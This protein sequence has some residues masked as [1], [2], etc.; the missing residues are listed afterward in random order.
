MRLSQCCAYSP[1]PT[2]KINNST[3]LIWIFLGI[4]RSFQFIL[5]LHLCMHMNACR[6]GYTCTHECVHGSVHAWMCTYVSVC[7][8]SAVTLVPWHSVQ[9]SLLWHQRFSPVLCQFFSGT[10]NCNKLVHKFQSTT[11]WWLTFRP[12]TIIY[13]DNNLF[14]HIKL[15]VSEGHTATGLCSD[16]TRC[17]NM[18]KVLTKGIF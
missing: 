2:G 18:A 12:V 9:H 6:C 13:V 4:S 5:H 7:N 16:I 17:K 14:A 11:N 10:Q 15:Q 8:D 1:V 3:T